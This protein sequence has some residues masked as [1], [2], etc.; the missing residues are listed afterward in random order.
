MIASS[1]FFSSCQRNGKTAPTTAEPVATTTEAPTAT[2]PPTPLDTNLPAPIA[3]N[4]PKVTEYSFVL[5]DQKDGTYGYEVLKSGKLVISQPNIPGQNGTSGFK[6]KEQASAAAN[7][8]IGKLEQ[9]INPPTISE[10]E[11]KKIL[12]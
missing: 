2:T 7:L 11:L 9:G 3:P 8:V 1:T 10:K 6:T 4:A 5:L 12:K